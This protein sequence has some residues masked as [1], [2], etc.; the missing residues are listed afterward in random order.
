MKLYPV[1]SEFNYPVHSKFKLNLVSS[2]LA[3]VF[4]IGGGLLM[5]VALNK[6]ANN[7]VLKTCNQDLNQ[8]IYVRTFIGDTYGCV[9]R[10]VL[11]G[12]SAPIKP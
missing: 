7:R 1:H 10:A 11:Q 8:I 2:C 5:C 3:G 6:A 12:P 9:S 4:G